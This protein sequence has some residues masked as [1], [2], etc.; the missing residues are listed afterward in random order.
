MCVYACLYPCEWVGTLH[1]ILSSCIPHGKVNDDFVD[2]ANQPDE[3]II[4]RLRVL[5]DDLRVKGKIYNNQ[6][7]QFE[8]VNA[9]SH[10]VPLPGYHLVVLS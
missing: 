4:D 9:V 10:C 6:K 2:R 1:L 7:Q 3:V 8:R 5:E